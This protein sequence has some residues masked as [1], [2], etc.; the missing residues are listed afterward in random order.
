MKGST[1]I[2]KSSAVSK[3]TP[4]FPTALGPAASV[5][6]VEWAVPSWGDRKSALNGTAALN[7]LRKPEPAGPCQEPL[8]K[9]RL[10]RE[11]LLLPFLPFLP[12]LPLFCRPL[13]KGLFHATRG[14]QILSDTWW[15]RREGRGK[16]NRAW[17]AWP[18]KEFFQKKKEGGYCL[19]LWLL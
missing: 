19:L 15:R 4:L 1:Y 5:A 14:Y 17:E 10:Q 9:I 16:V 11:R 2:L 13:C 12:L 7:E 3:A 8:G 18:H 6:Q